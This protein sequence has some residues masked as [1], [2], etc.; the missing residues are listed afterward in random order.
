M[1]SRSRS[2]GGLKPH[3]RRPWPIVGDTD[4]DAIYR[5]VGEA[6]STWESVEA[7]LARLCSERRRQVHYA[8]R[9]FGDVMNFAGR[10]NGIVHG[11]IGHFHLLPLPELRISA[12]WCLYPSYIMT[13]SRTVI[14]TAEY[15]MSF[16]EIGYF[17]ERFMDLRADA[18]GH[19]TRCDEYPAPII[20]INISSPTPGDARIAAQI[21][22]VSTK[23]SG[24]R[25]FFTA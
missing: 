14:E 1:A 21:E 4:L 11:T 20:S 22:D 17:I 24:C 10:R 13:K 25:L 5:S 18:W 23:R 15:A 2:S 12:S 6:V 3:D 16:V 8:K 9:L 7:A 19:Y